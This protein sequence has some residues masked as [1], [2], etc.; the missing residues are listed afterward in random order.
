VDELVEAIANGSDTINAAAGDTDGFREAWEGFKN[1]LKITLEPAATA[2]FG[3]MSELVGELRPAA[4][5]VVEAFEKDGLQGA[6]EKVAEEWDKI[7][8]EKIQPL[9]IKFLEFL[10]E[11]VKPIALQLGNAIG[12][13]IASG[14]WSAFKSGVSSLFGAKFGERVLSDLGASGEFSFPTEFTM[15]FSQGGPLSMPSMGG[16]VALPG[17]PAPR[18]VTVT[19]GDIPFMAAGGIVS[20]P[21]LAMIGEA[22]PE[23]VIPLDRMGGGMGDSYVINVSGALDAEGTARTILRVLRDAQRRS[24]DRLTV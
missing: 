21:T 17:A 10:N 6:L 12:G 24:G 2:V 19:Y 1:Y 11:T 23:A 14:M 7:Y 20:G 3:H 16:A 8:A 18:T 5:R 15:P 4:D 13:A 22:G 9:F